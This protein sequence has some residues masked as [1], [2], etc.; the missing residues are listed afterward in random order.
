MDALAPIRVIGNIEIEQSVLGRLLLDNDAYQNIA[1]KL[2]P[3]HFIDPV[4]GRL[5]RI[6][7]SRISAG[8]LVDVRAIKGYLNSNEALGDISVREY[9]ARLASE[10]APLPALESYARQ[11]VDLSAR[12]RILDVARDAETAALEYPLD[13]SVAKLLDQVEGAFAELRQSHRVGPPELS[14]KTA[15]NEAMELIGAAHSGSIVGIDYCLREIELV[16]HGPMQATDLIGLIGS[17][18]D[19]KSSLA[20]QQGRYSAEQGHPFYFLS[21]EQSRA[22][23]VLQMSAQRLGIEV[24]HMLKRDGLSQEEAD[25]VFEDAQALSKLPWTV[26]KWT[27]ST[28]SNLAV[29]VRAFVKRYGPGL[30]AID[31]AKKI[32]PNND[33]ANLADQ[34]SQ[35]YNDLKDI[36][37]DTGCTVLLLMHRNSDFMKRT[38]M[39]PIRSDSYGGEGSLQALDQC[40]TIYQPA[41]WLKQAAKRAETKKRQEQLEQQAYEASDKVEIGTLKSRRGDEERTMEVRFTRRFT[42]FE[43][44]DR[45]VLEPGLPI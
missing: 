10:A 25:E 26:E 27:Q 8:A 38:N 4:H 22:Q 23:C 12:R 16:M 15:I 43:T 13:E 45:I 36:A 31:N 30:V 5:F 6:I 33:R 32:K 39:A 21:G 11:I 35:V 20:L 44:L 18:G 17:S 34:V 28:V 14:P 2:N 7:A 9:V 40:M 42:R 1:Q 41:R 24:P 19:G 37:V 3:E 29:R